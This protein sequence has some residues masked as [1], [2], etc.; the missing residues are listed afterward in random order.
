MDAKFGHVLQSKQAPLLVP[1]HQAIALSVALVQPMV[2]LRSEAIGSQAAEQG[3]HIILSRG[4]CRCN[5][6]AHA[7]CTNEWLNI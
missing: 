2:L 3:A 5:P 1:A 4:A 6:I 7:E